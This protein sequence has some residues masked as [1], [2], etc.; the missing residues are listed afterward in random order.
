M[1]VGDF[2]SGNVRCGLL[3]FISFQMPSKIVYINSSRILRFG[4][5]LFFVRPI[6]GFV[7]ANGGNSTPIP[8]RG[9]MWLIVFEPIRFSHRLEPSR[10]GWFKMSCEFGP[11]SGYCLW[12]R[13]IMFLKSYGVIFSNLTSMIEK[14][15]IICYCTVLQLRHVAAAAAEE[16]THDAAVYSL[17]NHRKLFDLA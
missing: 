5:A 4:L 6:S 11:R 1:R 12:I 13:I 7:F 2:P 10:S 15:N 16:R 14:Y 3:G 8:L 17:T 9:G